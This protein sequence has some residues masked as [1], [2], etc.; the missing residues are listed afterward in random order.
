MRAI[1]EKHCNKK[2]E[3]WINRRQK[4][5]CIHMGKLYIINVAVLFYWFN[6]TLIKIPMEYHRILFY[7][8]KVP[9]MIYIAR[10]NACG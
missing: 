3:S 5:Q 4:K 2:K 8:L 7:N 10:V 6:I 1:W 9:F